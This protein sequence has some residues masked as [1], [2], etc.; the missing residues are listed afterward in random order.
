[1]SNKTEVETRFNILHNTMAGIHI[2]CY[3]SIFNIFQ[4]I[5]ILRIPDMFMQIIIYFNIFHRY[6]YPTCFIHENYQIFQLWI[7]TS[8]NIGDVIYRTLCSLLY[9]L[10]YNAGAVTLGLYR[11]GKEKMLT[12]QFW[13]YVIYQQIRCF[14]NMSM[15]K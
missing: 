12:T 7:R 8:I 3:L 14:Q 11:T 1:M 6:D 4:Y 9:L 10:V 5:S 15:K 2:M 13:K